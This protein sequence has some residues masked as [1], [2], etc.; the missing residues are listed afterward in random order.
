MIFTVI[1]DLLY[2]IIIIII[3]YNLSS[4]NKF[5]FISI[6]KAFLKFYK[7]KYVH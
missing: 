4:V 6:L 5:P 3:I 7:E 1:Q 2:T